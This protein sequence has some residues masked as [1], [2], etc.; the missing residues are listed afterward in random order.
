MLEG[1]NM[2]NFIRLVNATIV[3]GIVISLCGCGL[4]QNSSTKTSDPQSNTNVTVSD[5]TKS[6][7][8]ET[9]VQDTSTY[10]AWVQDADNNLCGY[11]D[12]T[13]KYIIAPQYATACSFSKNGLAAVEAADGESLGYGY[14]YIDIAGNFVMDP[15]F[16]QAGEYALNGLAAVT[17]Y[18]TSALSGYI[19]S[20]GYYAIARNSQCQSL[21]SG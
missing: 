19:D 20:T 16:Y 4:K 3:L 2:K 21:H 12:K 6:S 14:G 15:Q 18:D 5:T 1:D 7:T 10:L 9:T 13:G 8:S 17:D 11:I